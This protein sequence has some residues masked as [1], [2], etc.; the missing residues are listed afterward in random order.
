MT[1]LRSGNAA[2]AS[3]PT[4]WLLSGKER[5]PAYTDEFLRQHGA[6]AFSSI[7]MTANAFLTDDAWKLIVPLLIKGLRKIVEDRAYT[8]GVDRA[9]AARLLIGLTFDGFKSHLKNLIELIKMAAKNILALCENRDSSAIN[10]AFD[11]FVA[12]EGKRRAALCLDQFRRSHVSPII[13]QWHLVLVGLAMLRDCSASNAWENSFIAVNMHPLHR[14][15]FEDWL[16]KIAPAVRAAEKFET[17]VIDDFALLPAEW[18]RQ[19]LKFRQ[20]WLAIIDEESPPSW[21]VAVIERLRREGMGLSLAAQIFKIWATEKRIALKKK[22]GPISSSSKSSAVA[23]PPPA[24]SDKSKMLYHCFN[25]KMPGAT[26]EQRFMHAVTVRNRTYGPVK[27]VTIS[28]H[29]DVEVTEDNKKMLALSPEDINMHRILQDS[30]CNTG[31]RR[32]VARRCLNALGG[33]SGLSAFVNDPKAL[34]EIKQN[35]KFAESFEAVRHNERNIRESKAKQQRDKHYNA[36]ITKMGLSADCKV[37]KKHVEQTKLT[38]A[39][40]KAVAFVECGENISGRA[41]EVKQAL[42]DLL[43]KCLN[44]VET[45]EDM[46]ELVEYESSDDDDSEFEAFEAQHEHA[47]IVLDVPLERMVVGDCV[48]VWWKGDRKWYEGRIT[49][50]DMEEKQF[51]VEY[52]DDG[53]V[54]THNDSE[55]KVRMTV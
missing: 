46:P 53:K 10:Q 52:F 45:D 5:N 48:E 13:D 30:T 15:S 42:I 27:G 11:K 47:E 44:D 51:E 37:Y 7:I 19:P 4:F 29:L 1:Q 40:M 38:I 16:I 3:G 55:Y 23:T 43:P 9:T 17:E 32:K 14:V 39:Q 31:K 24:T 25:P 49:E 26:P 18:K 2:N 50:V 35:L 6:A 54:L 34:K 21:D 8:L 22:A 12:R 33:V 28:P 20:K 36:A 41:Q